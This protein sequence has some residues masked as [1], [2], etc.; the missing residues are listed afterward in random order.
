[1]PIDYSVADIAVG[2]GLENCE[3]R[4]VALDGDPHLRAWRQRLRQ[5]PAWP[6]RSA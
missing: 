2:C 4:G 3:A 1:M 6:D 5:R